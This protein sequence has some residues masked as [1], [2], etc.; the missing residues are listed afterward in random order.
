[1]SPSPKAA[2]F[3]RMRNLLYL[4]T[5]GLW[6]C[7]PLL[8]LVCRRPGCQEECGLLYDLFGI[9]GTTGFSATVFHCNIFS[10]P[11]TEAE[12]LALPREAYDN[13]EEIFNGGWR[14]D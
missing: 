7:W 9:K 13:A 8:P 6:P 2:D 12:F 3:E 4:S 11:T 5:P 14:V 10:A 1:M